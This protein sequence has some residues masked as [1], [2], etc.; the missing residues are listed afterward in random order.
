MSFSSETNDS[1][2]LKLCILGF[3]YKVGKSHATCWQMHNQFI[4]ISSCLLLLSCFLRNV[5]YMIGWFIDSLN[6]WPYDYIDSNWCYR[7][8]KPGQSCFFPWKANRKITSFYPSLWKRSF[9]LRSSLR[10]FTV[11]ALSLCLR[12]K[13]TLSGSP[14]VFPLPVSLLAHLPSF[15]TRPLSN[16][17]F[18][19]IS[20]CLEQSLT[21]RGQ[22]KV[23][24]WL[25]KQK[26]TPLANVI[27][28][29][30]LLF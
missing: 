23:V 3:L 13:L 14:M 28:W 30:I 12:I 2:E 21:E 4:Y 26:N 1:Q 9:P 15:A 22:K 20:F 27:I 6:D 10:K 19:Q 8:F 7:Y 5:L 25:R 11:V 24:H 18:C 16:F 17:D 29:Q